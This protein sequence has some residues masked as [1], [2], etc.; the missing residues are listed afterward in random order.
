MAAF[1]S[2]SRNGHAQIYAFMSRLSSRF[3]RRRR[4][5]KARADVFEQSASLLRQRI[6]D[7]RLMMGRANRC[8]FA[9]KSSARACF[10]TSALS[11]QDWR[12]RWRGPYFR[13]AAT[14]FFHSASSR[15]GAP[16]TPVINIAPGLGN[17][18]DEAGPHRA[19]TFCCRRDVVR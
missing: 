14:S 18:F 17:S 9:F 15:I 19:S 5:C 13:F 11:L 4:H 1:A 2:Q 6:A 3:D 7:F 16:R 12:P 8:F 10:S